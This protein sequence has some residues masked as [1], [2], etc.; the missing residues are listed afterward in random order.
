MTAPK[1]ITKSDPRRLVIEWTDGITTE[2]SARELRDVCP[3]AHC[4]DEHTGR[5]RYDPART[6]A[7]IETR[8][9]R[10]VGHYALAIGFSDS[11]DYGI[12]PWPMLRAAGSSTNRP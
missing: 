1:V 11:H 12:F 3:C 4:V 8:D 10:L 6:P 5:R 9:V 2:L 7:D